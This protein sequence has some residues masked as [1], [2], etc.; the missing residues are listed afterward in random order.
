MSSA[1][2]SKACMLVAGLLL[3][4]TVAAKVPALLAADPLAACPG[5]KAS[6]VKQS[7]TG[8][9]AD[10]KLGGKACNVFG[11]DLNDLVL[12]VTFDTGEF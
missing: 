4:P 6:N 5:Y 2:L 7:A 9:T 10:L 1:L 12:E 8:L 11:T 3:L